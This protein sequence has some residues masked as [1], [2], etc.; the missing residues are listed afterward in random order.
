M[1]S[2]RGTNITSGRQQFVHGANLGEFGG[3]R[4]FGIAAVD[5]LG[6]ILA[7][8]FDGATARMDE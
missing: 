1:R 5:A 6:M 8:R 4:L 7:D 2:T 3:G